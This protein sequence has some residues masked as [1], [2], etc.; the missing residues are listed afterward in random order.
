M[1]THIK[2]NHKYFCP[3][4]MAMNS[5]NNKQFNFVKPHSQ[6]TLW[7]LAIFVPLHREAYDYNV[8]VG[9]LANVSCNFKVLLHSS[10]ITSFS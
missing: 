4:I 6:Q 5:T 2:L 8:A 10:H 1:N 3:I 9:M 7:I